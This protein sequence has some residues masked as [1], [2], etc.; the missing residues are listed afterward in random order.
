[1]KPTKLDFRANQL[2]V[3]VELYMKIHDN[4]QHRSGAD[5][6][7]HFILSQIHCDFGKTCLLGALAKLLY[8]KHKIVPKRKVVVVNP[9]NWLAK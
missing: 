7:C 2:H 3:L 8:Q 9:N 5:K 1:M 6:K 4:D